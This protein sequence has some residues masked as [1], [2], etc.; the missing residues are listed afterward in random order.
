MIYKTAELSKDPIDALV[1]ETKIQFNLDKLAPVQRVAFEAMC[2]QVLSKK[3][4]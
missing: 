4:G 1:E 2:E 3:Y